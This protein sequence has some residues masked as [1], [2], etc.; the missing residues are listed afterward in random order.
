MTRKK[1]DK[2]KKNDA[3][4]QNAKNNA[5]ATSKRE[6]KTLVA[7]AIL[8][9]DSLKQPQLD[10]D[11]TTWKDRILG[12]G[13]HGLT[14]MTGFCSTPH[15]Q[16]EQRKPYTISDEEVDKFGYSSQ[17]LL[18]NPND[19]SKT[20][21][22]KFAGATDFFVHL[23]G[24]V[25]NGNE[26]TRSYSLVRKTA[27][28]LSESTL[29]KLNDTLYKDDPLAFTEVFAKTV[30]ANAT[31]E[32]LE[33]LPPDF[34]IN[35]D[36]EWHFDPNGQ[37]ANRKLIHIP[38][39]EILHNHILKKKHYHLTLIKKGIKPVGLRSFIAK[40]Q[41]SLGKIAVSE[42]TIEPLYTTIEQL[43]L[44][45]F[46]ASAAA[47]AE[48]KHRYDPKGN[49]ILPGFELED[50]MFYTHEQRLRCVNFARKIIQIVYDLK[51]ADRQRPTNEKNRYDAM[52]YICN[53]QDL[54]HYWGENLVEA[55]K[56]AW[57]PALKDEILSVACT[58]KDEL[59]RAEKI[60]NYEDRS[61][62]R[63]VQNECQ[64]RK[65]DF[66]RDLQYCNDILKALEDGTFPDD[67]QLFDASISY[68]SAFKDF[69][70]S[71]RQLTFFNLR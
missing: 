56:N 21:R 31:K 28:F 2:E 63:V 19:A 49:I 58:Y 52:W 46:H 67:R 65:H 5:M 54:Q 48:H 50:Y 70:E 43:W 36:Q 26:K 29:D 12:K 3:I 24:A 34:L 23:A 22:I 25:K 15:D 17:V 30:L 53:F 66:D 42:S 44:Y 40:I 16:D 6:V 20:A 18:E 4:E 62:S 32:D 7:T 8:Y 59:A 9:D 71:H 64:L 51:K 47:I 13:D 33:T 68:R 69:F 35:A 10:A 41:A 38:S 14:G 45:S 37:Y 57:I 11:G 55:V 39:Y 1:S 60:D 27:R 61:I